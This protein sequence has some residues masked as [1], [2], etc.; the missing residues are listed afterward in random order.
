MGAA[1]RAGASEILAGLAGRKVEWKMK[2]KYGWTLEERVSQLYCDGCPY[3]YRRPG[4][5]LIQCD[6]G[7]EPCLSQED[8]DDYRDRWGIDWLE[9]IEE[10]E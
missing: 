1:W 5:M 4:H 6:R 10:E 9:E 8:I 3:G 2:D 7:E